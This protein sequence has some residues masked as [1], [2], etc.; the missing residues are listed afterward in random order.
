MRRIYLILALFGLIFTAGSCKK[1][2][3]VFP[4]R[5]IVESENGTRIQNAEVR[6]FVPLPNVDIE[7]YGMTGVD[8]IANFQHNDGEIVME[9]QVTKGG[10][11]PTAVGCGYIKL[12]P[13]E[14]VSATIVVKAYDPEDP[15]CQ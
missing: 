3:P 5:I 14:L 7:Y 10:T 8:G 13:D 6:C 1:S 2:D 11:T 15:G 4:F 12:N 9:I